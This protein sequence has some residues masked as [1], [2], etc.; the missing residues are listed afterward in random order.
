LSQDDGGAW[1]CARARPSAEVVATRESR[2]AA[3]FRAL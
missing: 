2:I 3:L 1:Q